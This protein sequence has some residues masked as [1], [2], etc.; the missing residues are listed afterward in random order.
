MNLIN[1]DQ[2]TETDLYRIIGSAEH[3]KIHSALNQYHTELRGRILSNIFFESSTRTQ[4]SF[5]AAMYK[6]GGNVITLNNNS[7]RIKGESEE[8]TVAALSTYSDIAVIRHPENN[9]VEEL[10]KYSRVPVINGGDG[11]H[12]HPTQAILDLYTIYNYFK[13]LQSLKI[14]FTGDL[15]YSRTVSSL[16][17]VLKTLDRWKLEIIFAQEPGQFIRKA[18]EPNGYR[19]IP[20]ELIN[21]FLSKVDI[22]Y[23]TRPQLERHMPNQECVISDF[24]LDN[25]LANTMKEDAIIMHPFPR[26]SELNQDV[27]ENS[28][29]KYWEQAENGLYV[30][31]AILNDMLNF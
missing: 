16:I 31:M 9:R 12:E 4:H 11:S 13:H 5:E 28:R 3:R 23:M 26:N 30:R 15:C 10:A 25:S 21:H 18:T 17:T 27:D 22:L 1:A 20:E 7:A 8:D 24:K 14:L 29:A 6:L 19:V 2:L